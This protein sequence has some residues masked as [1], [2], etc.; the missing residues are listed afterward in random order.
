MYNILQ[1]NI[2]NE[3]MMLQDFHINRPYGR[4]G[5]HP[6]QGRWEGDVENFPYNQA[7]GPSSTL[8]ERRYPPAEA[9]AVIGKR[10]CEFPSMS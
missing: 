1:Q 2:R 7:L 9:T 4:W 5:K 3:A 6:P 8:A 10:A